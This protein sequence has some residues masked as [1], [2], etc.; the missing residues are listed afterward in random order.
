MS[1]AGDTVRV[2]LGQHVAIAAKPEASDRT[3]DRIKTQGAKGFI[4]RD[5]LKEHPSFD[6]KGG[7]LVESLVDE[8]RRGE[9]WMGWLPLEEIA[10]IGPWGV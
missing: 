4:V 1:W 3:V 8:G 5:H 10:A 9:R 7:L 6:R 2:K